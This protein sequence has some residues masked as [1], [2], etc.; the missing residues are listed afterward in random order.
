MKEVLHDR[1]IATE[2]KRQLK[3]KEAK[4]LALEKAK[5]L[6]T[7]KDIKEKEVKRLALEKAQIEA[8]INKHKPR[9]LK[10]PDKG[11]TL[12]TGKNA[13]IDG[14]EDTKKG[15]PSHKKAT[16]ASQIKMSQNKGDKSHK[17]KSDTLLGDPMVNTQNSI[18]KAKATEPKD[19]IGIDE[20]GIFEFIFEG[21][22]NPPDLEGIDEDRLFELQNAVQEQLRKR[23]EERE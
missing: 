23:D 15:K 21:L 18:N 5:R 10:T 3:E 11:N 7:V 13:K 14:K 12:G 16:K 19:T 20:I 6:Q 4:R 17:G 8:L 9:T 2:T 1:K 22:T